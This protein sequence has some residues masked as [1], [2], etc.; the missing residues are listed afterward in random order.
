MCPVGVAPAS[1]RGVPH[2]LPLQLP[3][4]QLS[5]GWVRHPQDVASLCPV[6][7]VRHRPRDHH[8]QARR[9][10]SCSGRG[11]GAR[12]PEACRPQR[13]WCVHNH[14]WPGCGQQGEA[15]AGQPR[16]EWPVGAGWKG[17]CALASAQWHE[18][19]KHSLHACIKGASRSRPGRAATRGISPQPIP[20]GPY[21]VASLAYPLS[22]SWRWCHAGFQASVCP[23]SCLPPPSAAVAV[24]E[25]DYKVTVQ[26][27]PDD[28][29]Y[30]MQWHHPKISSDKA[31]DTAQGSTAVKV[32]WGGQGRVASQLHINSSQL[33]CQAPGSCSMTNAAWR[34]AHAMPAGVPRG[35]RRACGPSGPRCQRAQGLELRAAGAGELPQAHG[36]P[37][38]PLSAGCC[39]QACPPARIWPPT[40]G[41]PVSGSTSA[42]TAGSDTSFF[43]L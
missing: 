26:W 14:R 23:L 33:L 20:P 3:C 36:R 24:V 12:V 16:W 25:P 34:P 10:G 38:L 4:M 43:L 19:G 30:S 11:G 6:A 7:D 42:A 22:F 32:G 41:C 17:R 2:Q 18:R 5:L 28:T 15:A 1:C 9:G 27:K 13:R 40:G 39:S 35:Q 31:W 21:G 37:C 8:L 29:F